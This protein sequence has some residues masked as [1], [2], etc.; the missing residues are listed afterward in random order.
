MKFI[1]KL[2]LTIF[3]ILILILSLI[4][5]LLVFGWLKT[6]TVLYLLQ[7]ALAMPTAVN[8]ILVISVIMMLLAIKCIF[9]SSTAKENKEKSDG[10]LLENENGKLLISISTIENLVKG[11]VATFYSVKYSKCNVKLDR[12]DNNVKVD[13]NLKVTADT[14]IKEL[15]VNIQDK[16]KETVKQATDLEIKEINIEIEDLEAENEN[17]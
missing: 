2:S 17:N 11:V 3:S 9:F 5:C 14:V 8:I 10:I 1:E 13:L 15:S 7:T 12:Q 6:S 16:I 4:M